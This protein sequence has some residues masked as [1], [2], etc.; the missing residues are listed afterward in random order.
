MAKTLKQMLKGYEPKADDEK[1]FKDKH[2]VNKTEDKNGNKDD[3]FSAT[4]IKS[5]DRA[6]TRHGYNPGQDADVYEAAESPKKNQDVADK[7]YLKHKPGTVKGTL[8]QFGRF[9]AGKPEIKEDVEQVDEK[10]GA[11]ATAGDYIKDFKKS[12]APQFAGKSKEK[13]KKMALAAFLNKESVE[14]KDAEEL[15]EEVDTTLL[16]LYA[17]LDE[18]NQS[19]MIRMIDEGRKDELLQFVEAIEE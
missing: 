9:I 7:A 17:Q 1:K 13:R 8:Q 18:D 3:V 15:D 12:D 10:L 11:G 2:T 14:Y 16:A 6:G 4:N 19:I 5:I